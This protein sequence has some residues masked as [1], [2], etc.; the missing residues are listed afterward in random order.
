MKANRRAVAAEDLLY[1]N[2]TLGVVPW[3]FL[4]SRLHTAGAEEALSG[5]VTALTYT[6][7]RPL[8]LAHHAVVIPR[9]LIVAEE[10]EEQ[11]LEIFI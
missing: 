2:K 7:T 9:V 1:N 11:G 8:Y 3:D 5:S 10:Q 6:V 4:L